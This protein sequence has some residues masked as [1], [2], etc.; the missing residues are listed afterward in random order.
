MLL[1][2]GSKGD[3]VK[4]LQEKLGLTADGIFGM[5]TQ[6]AVKKW[7]SRNGLIADGIVG[8]K[9]WSKM[10][11]TPVNINEKKSIIEPVANTL[12]IADKVEDYDIKE[13][14]NLLPVQYKNPDKELR[15]LAWT[16]LEEM[17]LTSSWVGN[18]VY[19]LRLNE[20]LDIIKE[21][22]FAPYFLVVRNMINWAKKEGIMVGPGRGSSA[23]SL[24]CYTLGITDID[25][26]EHGLLFFRFI[27]P[28]RNDFPDIDTDIQDS[29]RDEVKDYLVKQYRHVASIATFLQFKDKGVVRDVS[30]VLNIPLTDVNK[31]LKTV[32]T[33]DE[34]CTSRASAWFRE[35][36]PEVEVYGEQLRG[37]IR[38]TG[39][40]AAGV[41]TSKDPILFTVYL[42]FKIS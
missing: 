9:T 29:R 26:I 35:K 4:K 7:Q 21:K 15:E 32:D 23:G 22:K 38:G 12:E 16:A 1:K 42:H 8:A 25:P 19:E 40:H 33:W 34:F 14:L 5:G 41:V 6:N 17:H 11:S 3:D 18:D 13:D 37:R 10:F 28:E 39:I 2:I 20:E 27:N 30:R 36:Y 24:L 31:V